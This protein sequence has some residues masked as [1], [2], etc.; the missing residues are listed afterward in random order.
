M[1]DVRDVVQAVGVE[2][3]AIPADLGFQGAMRFTGV[4][5]DSRTLRPGE[6]FVPLIGE[7]FDGH[8]YL[9]EAFRKGA[10]GAVVSRAERLPAACSSGWIF[11]VV[12]T[13]HALGRLGARVRTKYAPVVIAVTGSVGK[14]T[15]KELIYTLI[16]QRF[17]AIR[18]E[19]SFNNAVGGPLSLLKIRPDTQV[20]V[21]ELGTNHPGE[22]D[23]LGALVRPD[24]VVLTRIAETHLEGF[25]DLRGVMKAKAELV[26][27]LPASGEL[28]TNGDD[29]LCLEIAEAFPGRVTTFGRGKGCDLRGEI[30][31]DRGDALLVRVGSFRADRSHGSGSRRQVPPADMEPCLVE[32]PLP[33]RHNLNNA[34]AA[35]GTAWRLGV[36]WPSERHPFRDLRL[37]PGRVRLEE[38]GGVV[39][40]DDTYNASPPSMEAALALLSR[41]PE[42]RRRIAVLGDMLELGACSADRHRNL[43]RKLAR[44]GVDLFLATGDGMGHAVREA[45]RAG[46]PAARAILCKDLDGVVWRLRPVLRPGDV[47]LFKGSRAMGLERALASLRKSLRRRDDDR[48]VERRA[49]Q[50]WGAGERAAGRHSIP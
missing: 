6:L 11:S 31:E 28:I 38:V 41:Y 12:D 30:L 10:A 19:K 4:S 33:G 2:P 27:H 39:L 23:Y 17:R 29:P 44:T 16:R 26:R 43:G 46:I 7:R 14:T 22:L 32:I 20:A 42:A 47:V 50:A 36:E 15:T 8:D 25:G 34:L 24:C 49:T 35:L 9:E 40:I 3:K 18:S 13:L 21:L 37:P 1:L 48:R 5:T 45:R